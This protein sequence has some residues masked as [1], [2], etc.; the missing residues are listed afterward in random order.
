MK[1]IIIG[2]GKVG[3]TLAEQLSKEENSVTVIDR[4]FDVV[5]SLSN[6]LDVIGLMGNGASYLTQV[7]AGI[8]EADL[9]IAVTGS[10]ELNLLC[11]LISKK[12]GNCQTI[13]RV[14]NP[15]YNQEIRFIKEEL[16]LA[17]VI[18][19]EYEA[20]M[21]IARVMRFPSAIKI[22]PFAKGR[23]ELLKFKI[24]EGSVLHN[25]EV[26]EI[27]SKL[28]C[29]VLVCMVERKDEVIIPTGTFELHEKDIVSIV[30][31][32]K[33]SNNFFK[34]IKVGT[35]RA[36]TA[37]I[38]G[39]G[40]I[41]YYLANQLIRMGIDVEIV[42]KCR[43]RCEVL[44]ELIPKATIIHGDGINQN[45]LLEEGLSRMD[46]FIALTNLDE[47]NIVLS[48]FA[49]SKG[50]MKTVTKINS[51]NF[52]EVIDGLDLDSVVYP[53]YVTSESIIRFVRAMKN[54]IGSNV[55]TLYRLV[56]NKVE[57]LEFI[58]KDNA[59]LLNISLEELEL[60]NGLL[61][62]CIHRNGQII[63]PKGKDVIKM[64]D[65]VVIVTTNTGLN[66]ISDILQN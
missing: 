32:P 52:D 25:M 64:G 62:A 46:A 6:E 11:C 1:I 58:I 16:G 7:E 17:M 2:C 47:V 49:R 14:R 12:A 57:A 30:A 44:S 50:D 60:K 8:E 41:A 55:E 27:S 56:G 22:E 20:A 15:E 33:L 42:E 26:R 18:N 28:R 35:N 45:L 54:S 43:D 37:M 40:S 63:I 23:V 10:D 51:I 19:P 66:D 48:L 24:R 38:V 9:M 53:K 29:D 5:Q 59:P 21:E 4:K 13:A 3:A 34:H 65:T 36:H 31:P 61:I 39:G